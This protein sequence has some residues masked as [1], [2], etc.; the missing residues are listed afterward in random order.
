MRRTAVR[1]SLLALATA[2]AALPAQGQTRARATLF[3]EAFDVS[4]GGTLQVDVGDMDI[5]VETGGQGRVEIIAEARD[6]DFARERFQEMRFEAFRDGNAIRVRTDERDRNFD[7]REWQRRGGAHYVARITIPGRFDL[8]LQTGDGD[9]E[10]GTI[11][12]A[13]DV[14]TG[15]GDVTIESASGSRVEL[16]TGDGDLWVGRLAAR[17]IDLHTGDGDVRLDR[18][19]GSI[20][21]RTGDGDVRMEIDDFDGLVVRTGDGDVTVT[22]DPDIS[23]DVELRAEDLSMDRAFAI[24]GRPGRHSIEGTMNGGGP[25]LRVTTGDGQVTIRAR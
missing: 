11:E 4:A 19:S 25:P 16:G 21:A 22:V 7:R 18:A 6:L 2:F 24:T 17:E 23:A 3:E 13:V 9:V 8:D 15:D 10:I 1:L 20:T 14:S 5:V 12:G